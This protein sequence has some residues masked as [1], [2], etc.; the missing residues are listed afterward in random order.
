LTPGTALMNE[1][2]GLVI[3]TPP[4]GQELI[5]NKL[6]NWEHCIHEAEDIDPLA[7]L[8]VMHYQFEAIH[9]FIDG[10]GRTGHVLNLVYLVDKAF[11]IFQSCT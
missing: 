2:T 4:E 11:W 1:A 6:A 5:R 7:S 3:Y 8:A 10:N 9:S